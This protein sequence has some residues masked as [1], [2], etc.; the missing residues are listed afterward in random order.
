MHPLDNVI[1]KALTTKQANFAE[2]NGSARRFPVE[3]TTLGAFS[4]AEA[5]GYQDLAKLL[6]PGEVVALFLPAPSTPSD[7]LKV[8]RDLPLLE[9]IY[10]GSAIS[11][12]KPDFVELGDADSPEMLALTKL[13][14]PGPFGK[15]THKLGTYLGIRRKG[16]LV[17]MAGERLKIEGHTEVSA[18]CTHPDHLGKGYAATLMSELMRRMIDRGEIPFLHVLESNERAIALY[19]RLGFSDRTKL[20]VLVFAKS[21]GRNR[22]NQP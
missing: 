9:M 5:Q 12:P 22:Q 19:R 17:A 1:W 7:S 2:V 4:G 6:R 20:R 8:T 13:T 3:V 10:D 14:Q 21:A 18:V 15:R 16:K 11:T